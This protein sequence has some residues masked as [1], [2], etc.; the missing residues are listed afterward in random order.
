M[1][2]GWLL[3]PSRKRCS[4]LKLSITLITSKHI[5]NTTKFSHGQTKRVNLWFANVVHQLEAQAK[6]AITSMP[7]TNGSSIYELWECIDVGVRAWESDFEVR[8]WVGAHMHVGVV[9]G[10]SCG[11][12][13]GFAPW[14][15]HFTRAMCHHSPIHLCHMPCIASPPWL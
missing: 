11:V 15:F 1:Q 10:G 13:L 14:C 3:Q 8:G 4:N 9:D 5:P 12:F 2:E 7:S 6:V